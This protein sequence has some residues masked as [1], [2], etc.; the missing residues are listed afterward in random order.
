LEGRVGALD[1]PDELR[2]FVVVTLKTLSFWRNRV[3]SMIF[4]SS[5]SFRSR[6]S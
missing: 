2:D 1:L 5:Y 6:E 4:S 3:A